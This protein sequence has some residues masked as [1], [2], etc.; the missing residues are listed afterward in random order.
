MMIL[1]VIRDA[2]SEYVVFFLL[3]AYL[4]A[5]YFAAKLPQYATSLPING[6]ADIEMRLRRLTDEFYGPGV[7]PRDKPLAEVDAALSLFD[8][9][10]SRLTLLELDGKAAVRRARHAL[11]P[12]PEP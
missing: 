10:L 8:A 6:P 3:A 9:A 1:D 11:S 7:S 2:D 12:P 4:E 5:A